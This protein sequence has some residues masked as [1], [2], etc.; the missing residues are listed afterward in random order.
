MPSDAEGQG[1]TL[2]VMTSAINSLQTDMSDMMTSI[3]HLRA[4]VGLVSGS[5]SGLRLEVSDSMNVFTPEV[6]KI[7]SVVDNLE[8]ELSNVS[9]EVSDISRK[10]SNLGTS[11]DEL[12]S[13][14]K[15]QA[16]NILQ[17][18]SCSID[19]RDK[20]DR[21][22]KVTA[23]SNTKLG[24]EVAGNSS[25]TADVGSEIKT[26]TSVVRKLRVDTSMEMTSLT[27][28]VTSLSGDVTSL[29][30][31]ITKRESDDATNTATIK[32]M[33]T[34]MRSLSDDIKTQNKKLSEVQKEV[35]REGDANLILK[36][37][38]QS[39]VD[40]VVS[41][42][43][44]TREILQQTRQTRSSYTCDFFLYDI[45]RW[46][47]A[48]QKQYSRLWYI[49]Q[50][51]SHMKGCVEFTSDNKIDVWLVHGRYPRVVGMSPAQD[52]IMKVKVSVVN[53]IGGSD[54][55]LGSRDWTAGEDGIDARCDGWDGVIGRDISNISCDE[56]DTR[57]LVYG[58]RVLIRYEITVV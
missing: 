45:S 54:W 3:K 50:M 6:K 5:I 30:E 22:T 8:A 32:S 36:R 40:Q 17:L 23:Y 35:G 47:G 9:Q 1:N 11:L 7:S 34:Q 26:L 37:L 49:D 4:E 53:Q 46:K 57:S 19:V 41:E 27:A 10:T 18:Q 14:H 42:A 55:Q 52:V 24:E 28:H 15:D 25:M 21:L 33:S 43:N 12:T 44:L 39:L 20:L 51:K 56:L 13:Q 48:G 16:D 2:K 31:E 29:T 58:D 38:G